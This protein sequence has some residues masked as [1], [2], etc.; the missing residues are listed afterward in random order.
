MVDF[1]SFHDE[2]PNVLCTKVV[3]HVV[4]QSRIYICGC[5]PVKREKPQTPT[6]DWSL[7]S[8]REK[9]EMGLADAW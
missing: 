9:R 7:C 1:F 8:E 4:E 5:T 3:T 6:L 2:F